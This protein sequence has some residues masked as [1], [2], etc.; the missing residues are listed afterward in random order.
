MYIESDALLMKI[1]SIAVSVARSTNDLVTFREY[2]ALP[3]Y[4]GNIMLRF[5]LNAETCT[6]DELHRLEKLIYQAAGDEFLIDFMGD[7]YQKIGVNPMALG[8]KLHEL[9][10]RFHDEPILDSVHKDKVLEDARSLQKL[11]GVSRFARVWEIQPGNPTLMLILGKQNALFKKT[12]L[13]DR[14][15]L[16]VMEVTEEECEGLMRAAFYAKRNHVSLGSLLL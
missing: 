10:V 3:H 1:A 7:V 11:A 12:A 8:E 16:V 4:G 2:I 5:D 14:R 6:A 13:P 15:P 9:F